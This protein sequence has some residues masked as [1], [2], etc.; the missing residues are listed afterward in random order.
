[1]SALYEVRQQP[2]FPSSGY[3]ELRRGSGHDPDEEPSAFPHGIEEAVDGIMMRGEQQVVGDR[4]STALVFDL[5]ACAVGRYAIPVLLVDTRTATASD[6]NTERATSAIGCSTD[7]VRLLL[8]HESGTDNGARL[9]QLRE[10]IHK[11]TAQHGSDGG[12]FFAVVKASEPEEQ[13]VSSPA[14]VA[15]AA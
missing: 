12:L 8:V 15:I 4:N 1:M 2:E 7:P 5:G 10:A 6:K 3:V 11:A 14:S 13:H 9:A